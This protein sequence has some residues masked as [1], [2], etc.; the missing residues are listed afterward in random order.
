[1]TGADVP[2]RQMRQIEQI[3]PMR[4]GEIPLNKITD[5]ELENEMELIK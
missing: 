2:R 5:M 1:M 4:K 3:L